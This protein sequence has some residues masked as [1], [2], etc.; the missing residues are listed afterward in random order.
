M[1]KKSWL[2]EIEKRFPWSFFGVLL[3]LAFGAYAVATT[4]IEK[5]PVVEYQL[6]NAANVLDL[7]KPVQDLK[8]S[9]R[10]E[11]IQEGKKNLKIYTIRIANIGGVDILESHFD[12]K[13]DWGIRFSN[14]EIVQAPRVVDANSQYLRDNIAP[15]AGTNNIVAFRKTILERGKYFTVEILVLHDKDTS[16]QLS[17]LGKIA[18]IDNPQVT[19]VPQKEISFLGKVFFGDWL[20]QLARAVLYFFGMVFAIVGLVGMSEAISYI[21]R[22]RRRKRF[23]QRLSPFL[24]SLEEEDHERVEKLAMQTDCSVDR[25]KSILTAVTDAETVQMHLEMAKDWEERRKIHKNGERD[26]PLMIHQEVPKEFITKTGE[27]DFAVDEDAVSTL[28]S[29]IKYL[30]SEKTE[31]R[32]KGSTDI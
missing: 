4:I 16:P 24:A 27:G 20:V 3:A 26:M 12:S 13:Q 30:E 1:T 23:R 17:V 28:R 6:I 7:H 32:T 21:N 18:G 2:L 9:F 29:L 14:A 31:N 8:I 22:K 25:L 5:R 10:G 11:D 15:V 19:P